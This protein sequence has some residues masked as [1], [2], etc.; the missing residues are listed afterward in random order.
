ML[1][2]IFGALGNGF[3]VKSLQSGELSVL[4]PVNAY[5]SVVGLVFGIFLLREIPGSAGLVGMA[6]IVA[7]S[8]FVL[9][10]PERGGRFSLALFRRKDLRLR[11]AAMIFA[12]VEAIFVKKVILLSDPN[13]A[14]YL[15][16]WSGAVFSLLFLPFQETLSWNREFRIGA[17]RI[18]LYLGLVASVGVMQWSTNYVFDHMPVGY[19]LALF[20]LSA[21]L[22]VFYGYVFFRE[23]HI[24]YK[25]LGSL[26]MIG[27]SILIILGSR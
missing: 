9:Q 7:G 5:K 22:S 2:G 3:L 21:V 8:Y 11:I 23:K 16:C 13:V 20:Q 6:L 14:F 19:A 10:T 4:G 26:V 27:G 12:A 25:L 24:L 15:W 17:G 18:P 1:V